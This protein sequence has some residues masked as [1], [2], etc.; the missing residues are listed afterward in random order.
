MLKVG[1]VVKSEAEAKRL[2]SVALWKHLQSLWLRSDIC[3]RACGVPSCAQTCAL[4]S[5]HSSLTYDPDVRAKLPSGSE[6]AKRLSR[7]VK[8]TVDLLGVFAFL[9]SNRGL[10][11]R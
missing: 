5:R 3:N 11:Y 8:E 7:T 9:F 10:Y 6:I 1:V 4:S 2:K